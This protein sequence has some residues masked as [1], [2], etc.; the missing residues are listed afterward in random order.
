MS[1]VTNAASRQGKRAREN[2]GSTNPAPGSQFAPF[3][4]AHSI[5]TKADVL[6]PLSLGS[7]TTNG[8]TIHGPLHDPYQSNANGT[9]H[10]GD[11]TPYGSL[12]EFGISYVGL[13]VLKF[14]SIIKIPQILGD[15]EIQGD[16]TLT[17]DII[18]QSG[19]T[20]N[21][22][23]TDNIQHS[24]PDD[25]TGQLN[26]W[27]NVSS[28]QV[29]VASKTP[30]IHIAKQSNG[31][32]IFGDA[33]LGVPL[34]NGVTI[35]ALNTVVRGDFK[36]NGKYVG[37]SP[38]DT[39]EMFTDHTSDNIQIGNATSGNANVSV[40]SFGGNVELRSHGT[41]SVHLQ[42]NLGIIT[43]NN[44]KAEISHGDKILLDNTGSGGIVLTQSGSAGSIN[45]TN[46]TASGGMTIGNVGT[47]PLAISS[48]TALNLASS[49]N[50]VNLTGGSNVVITASAGKTEVKATTGN[51]ELTSGNDVIVTADM[52]RDI[53]IHPTQILGDV[54]IGNASAT[55]GTVK[56]LSELRPTAGISFNSGND[57][58]NWYEEG[59][60]TASL[61]FGTTSE[62]LS[63]NNGYYL[64]IGNFCK[65]SLRILYTTKA[66]TGDF[67]IRG[68]P[69]TTRNGIQCY[70][71]LPLGT[72]DCINI[73]TDQSLVFQLPPNDT[74]IQGR[75]VDNVAGTFRTA[76]DTDFDPSGGILISGSYMTS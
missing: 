10:M 66:G 2:P 38:T 50:N 13:G 48:N 33:T 63:A 23:Y 1:F 47:T 35:S 49:A 26:I 37:P 5:N 51:V 25:G 39:V 11:G 32:V 68:L 40:Q 44:S 14:N 8:I 30:K 12:R 60:F 16:L 67:E 65:F 75:I 71:H 41:G 15:V 28:N 21:P 22:L 36:V 45:I 53:Q 3:K 59:E 6:S 18:S 72:L 56:T 27:N 55:T 74:K 42:A 17:G 69:F 43:V 61:Y 19:L 52:A 76:N 31:E 46:N 58:L 34:L 54:E 64:R 7:S 57:V 24:G 73:S 20:I 29:F 4:T 62:S 70:Q 9:K